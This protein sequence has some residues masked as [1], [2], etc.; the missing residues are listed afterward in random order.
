V[1]AIGPLKV[2]GTGCCRVFIAKLGSDRGDKLR[3][4]LFIVDNE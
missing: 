2:G 3:E 4:L 1:L